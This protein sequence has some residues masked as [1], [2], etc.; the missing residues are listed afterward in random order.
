MIRHKIKT[1]R[2]VLRRI[3]GPTA[4]MIGKD[5]SSVS[6]IEETVRLFDQLP[7]I[8]GRSHYILKLVASL[9]ADDIGEVVRQLK[10]KN[11]GMVGVIKELGFWFP[12]GDKHHIRQALVCAIGAV[13]ASSEATK[14]HHLE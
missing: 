4:A 12:K 6:P 10:I 7:P 8:N 5:A 11:P 3:H 9:T 13:A 14:L 1:D 2:V